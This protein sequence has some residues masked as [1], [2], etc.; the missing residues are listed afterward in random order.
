MIWSALEEIKPNWERLATAFYSMLPA[1]GSVIRHKDTHALG[2]VFA[3]SVYGVVISPVVLE[4]LNDEY[5]LVE[6]K[7]DE[8]GSMT[9]E[10]TVIYELD[11]WSVRSPRPVPP[12]VAKL[13]GLPATLHKKSPSLCIRRRDPKGTIAQHAARRGVNYVTVEQLK[14]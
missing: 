6:F 11:N 8:K 4:K 1:V 3:K 12:R 10:T 14:R 9:F 5:V 7:R 13:E 2:M